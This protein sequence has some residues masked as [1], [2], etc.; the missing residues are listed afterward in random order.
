[1]F[2]QIKSYLKFLFK[3]TNQH[4]IHSPFVYDFV[5]KC[6]YNRKA[7]AKY[8]LLDAFRKKLLQNNSVIQVTDFGSGSRVF[9][10]NKRA[11]KA[12]AKNAGVPIK[13]QHL[14]FRISNYFQPINVLELGTSLGLGT[15]ALS[16]GSSSA[17]IITI[18]GCPNTAKVAKQQFEEFQLQNI[19]LSVQNFDDF[20]NNDDTSNYDLVYIDGNHNK[21][22]TIQ[23]F[24][25]LLEKVH[26]DTLFIFDDIYWSKAMTE[27]WNTICQNHKVTVSID[28]FYWGFAFFRTAQ[29]KEHFIIRL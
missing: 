16:L 5:T 18:E 4:G 19:D 26:N 15:V 25:T 6:L 27:A 2:Y 1:M 20:L 23:Y 22:K 21:E 7:Y 29:E 9:S 10:S 17:N 24:N 28:C 14:L 12:I 11:V 3:S 8:E 13:R